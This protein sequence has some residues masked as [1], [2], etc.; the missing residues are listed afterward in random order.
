VSS[1][2]DHVY[3]TYIK[4]TPERLWQAL[5][6]GAITSRYYFGSSVKSDWKPGS[7]YEFTD[8]KGGVHINRDVVEADRPRRL[9]TTFNAV[10]DEE[11]KKDKPTMATFEIE[12]M[13]DVCKLTVIHSGFEG[14][15]ATYH[16]V[17]GG[18]PMIV[19]SL[20][21]LIETGE[22]LSVSRPQQMPV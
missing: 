3:S 6:D 18:W 2:P 20:K 16:Q 19:A 4:T 1:K 7:R 17:T 10:W 8:A 14:E 5:T 12:Q 9:V 11:V 21:S 15:T 13:G 22:P